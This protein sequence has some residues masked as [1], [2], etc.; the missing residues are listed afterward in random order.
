VPFSQ[1]VAEQVGWYV[2]ALRDP[3]DHSV[4]YIGKGRGNRVFQH[5]QD[6]LAP[7]SDSEMSPKLEL[8]RD[9]HVHGLQVESF[10]LRHGLASE[11][12]A[13]AVEAAVI[14]SLRLLDPR[15]NNER[16]SLTN[17]VLGHHHGSRGLASTDVVIRLFDAP[18]A[19]DITEAVLLIKIPD[20]WSPAMSAE[21][22]YRATRYWW[23]IGARREAARYAF[24]VNRGVIRE[25]YSIDSWRPWTDEES[26]RPGTTRWGFTG[27]VAQEMRHYVN[28][29]VKHLYKRGEAS[30]IKFINC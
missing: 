10:I 7:P 15:L 8:I 17:L 13:Y 24:S 12:A 21:A 19:P 2:Y 14:D 1:F 16:Y 5:A 30:P 9:I 20:L 18:P 6:A 27:S 3:R 28:T 22:L 29:S 25:V 23:R 26:D 4:F 11:N